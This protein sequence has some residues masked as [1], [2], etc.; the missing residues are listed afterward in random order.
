M[1]PP[2]TPHVPY[3]RYSNTPHHSLNMMYCLHWIYSIPPNR[4]YTNP[5]LHHRHIPHYMNSL[6]VHQTPPDWTNSTD[7]HFVLL[8]STPPGNSIP[9]YM[10]HYM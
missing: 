3:H 6:H 9:P 2:D 5:L 8:M 1:Y 7:T 10:H 4:L